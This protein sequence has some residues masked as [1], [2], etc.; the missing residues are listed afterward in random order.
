MTP[1]TAVDMDI[2]DL[3]D[4]TLSTGQPTWTTNLYKNNRHRDI[5]N[6]IGVS[7]EFETRM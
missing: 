6:I 5:R 4:L 7:N 1:V 2:D 3:S